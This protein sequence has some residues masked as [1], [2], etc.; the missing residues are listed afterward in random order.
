MATPAAEPSDMAIKLSLDVYKDQA[1]FTDMVRDVAVS[2]GNKASEEEVREQIKVLLKAVGGDPW[3]LQSL[4][5]VLGAEMESHLPW[6][7][8]VGVRI[9]K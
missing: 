2:L 3:K 7:R 6:A 8:S 1:E 9:Y 5:K 4:V